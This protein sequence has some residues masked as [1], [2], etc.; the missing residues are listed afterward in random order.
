MDLAFCFQETASVRRIMIL[1]IYVWIYENSVVVKKLYH[2]YAKSWENFEIVW[3][4][5]TKCKIDSCVLIQLHYLSHLAFS[6]LL[7][8]NIRHVFKPQFF[9]SFNRKHYRQSDNYFFDREW[10]WAIL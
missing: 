6:L 4:F 7:N 5:H 3:L 9:L 8:G 1:C 10:D 2:N